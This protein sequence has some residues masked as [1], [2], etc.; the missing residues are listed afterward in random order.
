MF[1]L[2][3]LKESQHAINEIAKLVNQEVRKNSALR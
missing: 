3:D 2:T 1:A